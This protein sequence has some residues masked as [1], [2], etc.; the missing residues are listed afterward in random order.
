MALP[1]L[2]LIEPD[3]DR[4]YLPFPT[5]DVQQAYWVGRNATFELG[6]VGNHAYIE[7]EAIELDLAEEVHAADCTGW[8]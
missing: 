4:R 8:D 2:P 6:N 5:T 1:V 3:L 7:V